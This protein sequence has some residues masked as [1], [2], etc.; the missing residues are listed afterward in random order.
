MNLIPDVFVTDG[1]LYAEISYSGEF[2]SKETMDIP[3]EIY[4]KYDVSKG[5]MN[6]ITALVSFKVY[7]S[8]DKTKLVY[9]SDK[10]WVKGQMQTSTPSSG[11]VT[12]VSG[13]AQESAVEKMVTGWAKNKLDMLYGMGVRTRAMN[14][15]RLK[16]YDDKEEK[17]QSE[18]IQAKLITCVNTIRKDRGTDAY[19]ATLDECLAFYQKM[20]G[21][22]SPGTTKLKENQVTDNNVWCLY[23]NMA[24]ANFLKQNETEAKKYISKAYEIRK[25][26]NVKEITN[27][28]GEKIGEASGPQF[29]EGFAEI[30]VL[31]QNID[32]YFAGLKLMPK[33]FVEFVNSEDQMRSANL[34]A[35]EYAANIM[36]STLMGLETPASFVDQN[37]K[38]AT[39]PYNGSFSEKEKTVNYE[40]KKTWHAFLPLNFNKYV[41]KATSP[42]N[43]A[44]V[45]FGY[46]NSLLPKGVTN[47]NSYSLYLGDKKYFT[48][49]SGAYYSNAKSLTDKTLLYMGK[50][51]SKGNKNPFCGVKFQYDYDGDIIITGRIYKEKYW[52]Y[53]MV[54]TKPSEYLACTDFKAVLKNKDFKEVSE[55]TIDKT[56]IDRSRS[57]KF[58]EAF[59]Q[60]KISTDP[61]PTE[62]TN[63]TH[64]SKKVNLNS[65]TAKK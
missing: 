30:Q 9:E 42:Y 18:D 8:S 32:N 28:K 53:N 31:K 43:T 51:N 12:K 3:V 24:V 41:V 37:I 54:V 4:G 15:Y 57:M 60:K 14:A 40:V 35:R 61:I 38:D 16:G 34:L 6:D 44:S 23:Y 5:M 2:K 11:G 39:K 50:S 63:N 55:L 58:F 36:L 29:N 26:K 17:K 13:A 25:P 33:A 10:T 56:V 20:L 19:N 45:K 65:K 52:F 22:Y 62:E 46:T 7:T 49:Y 59:I 47:R 64:T 21:K 27:K 1:N 48:L